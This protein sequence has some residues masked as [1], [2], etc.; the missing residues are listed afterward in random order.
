MEIT[1]D[2]ILD[3]LPAYF[4]GEASKETVAIVE[5]FFADHPDFAAE[6]QKLK[7]DLLPNEIPQ[8]L[9]PEDEMKALKKTRSL[10]RLRSIFLPIA[11]FFTLLPFSFVASSERGLVMLVLRDFPGAAIVF[12]S[13][14]LICW[15]GYFVVRQRLSVTAL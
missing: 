14:A 3:L 12:G 15:I 9:T 13:I 8:T 7:T 11:I 6:A 2:I 5:N 4:S 10:I 1:K